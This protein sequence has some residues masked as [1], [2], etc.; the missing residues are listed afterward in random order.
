MTH[1]HAARRSSQLFAVEHVLEDHVL[2]YG[3]SGEH[4][5]LRQTLAERPCR[6][7]LGEYDRV[8]RAT[9]DKWAE[10][11]SRDPHSRLVSC[12]EALAMLQKSGLIG[13][14]VTQRQCRTILMKTLFD[15]TP[16]FAASMDN[17]VHLVYYEFIE[18][19]ARVSEL[20]FKSW[21]D[22]T[23]DRLKLMI[24]Q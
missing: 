24:Q 13:T 23:A 11:D 10:S 6:A 14:G 21:A 18:F 22:I 12:K 4:D 9:Y 2:E 5:P 3:S 7:V 15:P 16:R 1:P 19:I 8:M 17:G 20:Y